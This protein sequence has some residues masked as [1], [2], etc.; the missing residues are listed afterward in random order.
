M[1]LFKPDTPQ[2]PDPQTT[3]AA[4]TATS[5]E[6][7]LANQHLQNMNQV[8][9]DGST[10][11]ATTGQT[12]FTDPYTK[13][14]YQLPNV[15]KTT[16]LSPTGQAIH[17]AGNQTQLN[18]ANLGKSQSS[19]LQELLAKPYDGSNAAT[20]SR[21]MELGRS[22]LDPVMA[23]RTEQ[24]RT[25]L[26]NQGIAQGSAAYDHAMNLDNQSKNDAYNQLL[27]TGHNQ[28]YQEGYANYTNPVNIINSLQSGSQ[29]QMPQFTQI[30]QPQI[31]TTDNAGLI[32]SNYQAQVANAN[33]QYG[34]AQSTIGGLFGL[35]ASALKYSDRRLKKDIIRLGMTAKGYAKYVYRYIFDGPNAPYQSGF[36]AD[37]VA[38]F[39]PDAVVERNGFKMLNYEM[40]EAA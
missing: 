20:E 40:L 19:Y 31:A 36:M 39:V 3:S 14:T 27:L 17:D 4:Q 23:Q 5:V 28:A 16:T 13:Q 35:G 10:T 9:P 24:L 18:L 33:A 34:A 7:A 11:F 21:L 25:S 30:A 1:G 29:V 6:T 37:E 26:A 2:P 15:T 22:R 38:K 8:G 12:S 32:N